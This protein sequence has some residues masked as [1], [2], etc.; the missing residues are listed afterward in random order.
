MFKYKF[1][2]FHNNE[3][4]CQSIK[5]VSSY[6]GKSVTAVA[7]LHPGDEYDYETGKEI[8]RLRCENK[9]LNKKNKRF[10]RKKK[11]TLKEIEYLETYIAQLK[12]RAVAYENTAEKAADKIKDN[13]N[14][15]DE[16]MNKYSN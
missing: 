7:E 9:L 8:S 4:D 12:K 14:K 1:F 10:I 3:K 5:C 15:L 16:L 11:E 6:E 13:Y 2:E